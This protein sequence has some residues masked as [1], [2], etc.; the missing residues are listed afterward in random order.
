MSRGSL[1]DLVVA[2]FTRVLAGP[3][4]T[5][6]LGDLGARVIKVE[7][8]GVGDDTRAWGPPHTADGES[9]YYLAA[10]RNKESITLDLSSAE[11]RTVARQ[12]ADRAD[13]LVENF[14]PGQMDRFGLSYEE[15]A[16]TNPGVVYCSLTGFGTGAGASL[17]GY[18]PVVQAVGGLMSVTGPPGSPSKTGVA[19]VDVIS[20]LY[21]TIGILAALRD[22]DRT[23]AGQRVE[24]TLLG[25]ELAALANLASAYLH[26]GASPTA[27]GNAHPS[28]V[29]YQDFRTA[30]R[31]LFV[32]CGN[33]RQW[34]A[35][36]RVLDAEGTAGG[37][38]A[39][40][41][42]GRN[43]DRVAHRD[44][45]VPL[46]AAAFTRR[47]AEH[48]AD[49]LAAAGVPCGPVNDIGAAFELA[50]RLGLEPVVRMVEEDREV[51]QVASPL[52]LSGTPV[53]YHR[54]PPRLGADTVEVLRWLAGP[55]SGRH[56]PPPG[57]GHGG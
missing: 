12:L 8:P 52:R 27:M 16:T 28:I 39:D 1:D 34:R 53:R 44:V 21:A 11:G 18:D 2:D 9:T 25:S 45:L 40:P 32:G 38:A 36:C 33:D 19:L 46:L 20:G 54:A 47:S 17:P 29:P 24:L 48:W 42:F 57:S 55:D 30:D 41:R 10:N 14:R 3:L 56:A 5:M 51:Q 6:V 50:S 37:L 22:R 49:R 13:V 43:P 4:A 7:R 15:V 31:P 23:G 26:T 35:L